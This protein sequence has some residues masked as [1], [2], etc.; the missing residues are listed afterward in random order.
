MPVSAVTA[1]VYVSLPNVHTLTQSQLDTLYTAI[2]AAKIYAV[3]I[4]IPWNVVQPTNLTTYAWT[5]IDRAINRALLKDLQ[6][7]AVAAPPKPSWAPINFDP[8]LFS[9]FAAAIAARYKVRGRGL[10]SANRLKSVTQLQLWDQPNAPTA[11]TYMLPAN[12]VRMLRLAYPAVKKANPAGVTVIAA[13]LQACRTVLFGAN[14]AVDPVTYLKLMYALGA[15]S[16]FD[17]AAFNPLSVATPQNPTPPA[18]SGNTVK[19]S[20]ALRAMMVRAGDR[21]KKLH[22]SNVGYDTDLVS[23]RQ[24]AD[25]LET[26]RRFAELRKDHL[27]G[28]GI[29]TYQ[30]PAGGS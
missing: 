15:R 11:S 8:A 18:P 21:T 19:V 14:R 9:A 10:T 7:I 22:W 26:M 24:Q 5:D 6:V 30:D 2:K 4:P 1:R 20:D 28:I 23:Q 25:Y 16:L 17:A 13:A 29:Y 12:Y 3:R 27:A